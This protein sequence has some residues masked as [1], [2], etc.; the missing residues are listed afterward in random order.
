[1]APEFREGRARCRR[2]ERPGRMRDQ[3][4]G[5]EG[6]HLLGRF[7]ALHVTAGQGVA[8]LAVS[9]L[10]GDCV[11]RASTSHGRTRSVFATSL[12]YPERSRSTMR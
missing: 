12:A 10:A 3:R 8:G 2:D 5:D 7:V 11:A 1:M 6:A 9:E 4:R